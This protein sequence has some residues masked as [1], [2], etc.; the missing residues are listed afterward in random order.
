MGMEGHGIKLE[1]YILVYSQMIMCSMHLNAQGYMSCSHEEIEYDEDARSSVCR[2]CGLVMTQSDLVEASTYL[3][4]RPVTTSPGNPYWEQFK[5]ID[6]LCERFSLA[7]SEAAKQLFNQLREAHKTLASRGK[8]GRLAAAISVLQ[9]NR[10]SGSSAAL[11]LADLSDAIDEPLLALGSYYYQAWKLAPELFL[12]QKEGRHDVTLMIERL[13]METVRPWL[14]RSGLVIS[15]HRRLLALAQSLSRLGN[16]AWLSVGRKPE[17]YA[18]A[19][20]LL[21]LDSVFAGLPKRKTPFGRQQKMALCALADVKWRTVELRK[22]ELA[23]YLVAEG[24]KVTPMSVTRQNVASHLED[25]VRVLEAMWPNE[26][27][28]GTLPP[29]F[30]ASQRQAAAMQALLVKAKR[31]IE[32]AQVEAEITETDLIIERLLLRHAKEE[33]ILACTSDGQ[34]YGLLSLYEP[35][36]DDS[37]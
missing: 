35:S 1:K 34:L 20:L 11:S 26:H 21:A 33:Q 18:L 4:S 36:M 17:P 28:T 5:L 37:D 24:Q 14:E 19:C 30:E 22:E 13:L 10:L 6:A 3:G 7:V 32:G 2:L 27:V 8:K 29:A 15:D 25:V 23:R 12:E 9:A 16:A 31:R